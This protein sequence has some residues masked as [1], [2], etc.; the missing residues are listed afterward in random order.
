MGYRCGW[1][2]SG[3]SRKKMAHSS[4]VI[5]DSV[6]KGQVTKLWTGFRENKKGECR[7]LGLVAAV[8]HY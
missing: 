4:W 7:I 1:C 3:S 8:S 6:I 5:E 2:K